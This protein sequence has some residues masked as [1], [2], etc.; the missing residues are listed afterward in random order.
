MMS[1]MAESQG[2]GMKVVNLDPAADVLPYPDTIIADIRNNVS[3]NDFK[4]VGSS[5]G[6]GLELVLK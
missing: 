3:F 4:E 2:R 6:G 1:N 5:I